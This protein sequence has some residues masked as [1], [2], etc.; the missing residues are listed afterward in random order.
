MQR[1]LVSLFVFVVFA[2]PPALADPVT[3]LPISITSGS[4]V[5]PDGS[6]ASTIN[7]QGT[8]DFKMSG[9]FEG[10]GQFGGNCHPCVPNTFADLGGFVNELGAT[11]ELP[12]TAARFDPS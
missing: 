12:S 9:F 7:L 5:V 8:R 3:I 10:L 2:V 11:A 4:I 1:V 6:V